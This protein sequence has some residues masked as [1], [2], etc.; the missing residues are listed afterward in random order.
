M[1]QK[2]SW[3]RDFEIAFCLESADS[4][5]TAESKG[6]KIQNT[7]LRIDH[8]TFFGQWKLYQYFSEN[9]WPLKPLKVLYQYCHHSEE[10]SGN[11]GWSPERSD[12]GGPYCTSILRND[13][14]ID[15]YIWPG[16]ILIVIMPT[17]VP[18]IVFFNFSK[19]PL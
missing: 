12:W 19:C 9:I 4:N 2:L 8:S 1:C 7:K 15:Q 17:F 5:C 13:D 18:N 3:K 16:T 11:T 14:S 10:L 6:G